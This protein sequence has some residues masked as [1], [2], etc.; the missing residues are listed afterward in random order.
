MDGR[1]IRCDVCHGDGFEPY[2]DGCGRGLARCRDC[3]LVMASSAAAPVDAGDG[4]APDGES[5]DARVDRRRAAAI[6][7]L[8]ASG[9]ILEV[10]CGE[11][12]FLSALDPSRYEVVGVERAAPTAAEARRRISEAGLRGSVLHGAL[13]AAGL[14]AETFDLVALFGSLAAS[15]SPRSTLIEVARLLRPGGYAVIET[16]CLSSLTALLLG[17]RWRPLRDTR[18]EFFF[19]VA[20]L[21]KL[22]STCGLSPGSAWLPM[23]VGWPS[24]GTLVYVTRKSAV[25]H[26]SAS[27]TDLASQVGK[28]APIG[29]AH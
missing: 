21:E 22:T 17:A 1:D 26:R 28:I 7:R 25:M 14:P 5:R 11:G 9:R 19:T 27:L 20:S 3:G 24:P 2:L 8:I 4:N 15:T 18:S 12:H 23:P 6:T 13:T 29:A 10:G 16:P